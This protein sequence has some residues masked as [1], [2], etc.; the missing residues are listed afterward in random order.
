[1]NNQS[2]TGEKHVSH[3]RVNGV[4]TAYRVEYRGEVRVFSIKKCGG[5]SDALK[6]AVLYRNFLLCNPENRER[7]RKTLAANYAPQKRSGGIS[8]V[9]GIYSHSD[10]N[11]FDGWTVKPIGDG[12]SKFFGVRKY[13]SKYNA[14]TAAIAYQQQHALAVATPPAPQLEVTPVVVAA[15]P[16]PLEPQS[17]FSFLPNWLRRWVG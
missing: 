6:A 10:R 3:Y 11:G 1:M 9:S 4:L 8:G 16:P 14:L 15:P 5:Q 17:L 2:T 12:R 13:G 7:I